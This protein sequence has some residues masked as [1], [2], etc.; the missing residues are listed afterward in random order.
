[1]VYDIIISARAKHD[2]IEIGKYIAMRLHAPLAARKLL[3]NVEKLISNLDQM[4]KRYGLVSDER[5]AK[6]GI[7][8]IPINNYIIFYVVNEN[9]KAVTIVSVMYSERNWMD[10]L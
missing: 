8:F 5:L 1:M 9:I 2:M 10:L 4:P 6:L 7:R 3:D